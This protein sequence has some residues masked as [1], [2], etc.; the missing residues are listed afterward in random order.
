M[1]QIR[2][3]H[4]VQIR[5]GD[6]AKNIGP[7]GFGSGV[8]K[9]TYLPQKVYFPQCFG[10]E[11]GCSILGQYGSG[12][13]NLMA[14]GNKKKFQ[15]ILWYS[16]RRK[17]PLLIKIRQCNSFTPTP[18]FSLVIYARDLD[19]AKVRIHADQDPD[20]KYTVSN[21][22]LLSS[23]PYISKPRLYYR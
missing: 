14:P 3:V 4:K 2:D 11:S 21:N 8:A 23:Y 10:S 9:L 13:R 6:R 22:V 18:L 17:C 12:S 5:N 16:W 19:P 15:N 20:P 7:T 1:I